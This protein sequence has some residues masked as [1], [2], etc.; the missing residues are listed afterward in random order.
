MAAAW[1]TLGHYLGEEWSG[2]V[3]VISLMYFT[4]SAWEI[5]KNVRAMRNEVGDLK[6]MTLDYEI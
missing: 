6:Y 3:V 2:G 1:T 4:F 5:K